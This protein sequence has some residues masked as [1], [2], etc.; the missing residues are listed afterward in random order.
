MIETN[1]TG[2][3]EVEILEEK[4]NHN[5]RNC[6]C[7]SLY[8]A[9]ALHICCILTLASV[10]PVSRDALIHHLAIPKMYLEHGG[11]Y[12]IPS[13]SFS[14]FPM[15]ID[16]L[17]LLPLY[18][19]ND[20]AANYIHFIFALLTAGLLFKYIKD[21]LGRTYGMLGALFFLT[22]PVIV[23]LSVT[24]Y[25]DLGLIFFSWAC[26]YSFLKWYDSNFKL[27]HLVLSGLWCGLALGTKYNG[28][29]LLLIMAAAVPLAF[30]IKM[31]HNLVN[32]E[33]LKKNINS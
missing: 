25:V 19:Q 27:R 10:P 15:N 6:F 14:Y 7:W 1:H 18:L 2:A 20:I 11:M 22:T 26:L 17:Y 12:E 33:H 29:I 3:A 28:L 13:M 16:L 24:A 5:W 4:I 23:K 21:S 31:N 9:L 8:I 30:S 32:N